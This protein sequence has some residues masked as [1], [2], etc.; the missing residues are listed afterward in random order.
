MPCSLYLN[1]S[2]DVLYIIYTIHTIHYT[3][4]YT[5]MLYTL[6]YYAVHTLQKLVSSLKS[7]QSMTRLLDD[8]RESNLKQA[9]ATLQMVSQWVR[10]TQFYCVCYRLE[11]LPIYIM[12][13]CTII[14]TNHTHIYYF[15]HY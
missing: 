13:I 1:L 8:L 3:L 5:T 12:R 7:V 6:Y 4:H 2:F 15:I 9:S 10:I 11:C 14:Y